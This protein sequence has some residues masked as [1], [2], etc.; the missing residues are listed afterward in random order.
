MNERLIIAG[1]VECYGG[2]WLIEYVPGAR[3]A[4]IYYNGHAVDLVSVRDWDFAL[5]YDAQTAP[6]PS[7]RQLES[8]LVSWVVENGGAYLA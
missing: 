8:T 6:I 5:G 3:T 1:P 2:P 7:H 4:D